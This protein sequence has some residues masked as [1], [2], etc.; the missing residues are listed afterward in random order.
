MRIDKFLANAKFGSRKDVKKI[1]KAKKVFVNGNL[2]LNDD[3]QVKE[4]DII[5]CDGKEVKYVEFV[6]YMLNKPTGYV[7]ATIDNLYPTVV[8]IID[9]YHD[10]FPV[11]RLDVDTTG[12]L[13]ITNDGELAH[14]L[15]SPKKKV[16]KKYFVKFTGE[17][18]ENI[19][20]EFKK[21]IDLKDYIT[22]PGIFE[23]ISD[24]SCYV[25]IHEGKFHQVKLMMKAVGLKVIELKRVSF[26]PIDLD[27]NLE[28]GQYRELTKS[29]LSILKNIPMEV[30]GE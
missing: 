19:P 21:G 8:S 24:D 7:S 15:T 29:E 2:V 25:T 4:N 3:Y 22:K 26:G 18:N 28:E 16:D 6:Y 9:D 11:G 20:E 23:K 14:N 17:Y 10:I 30:E 5:I 27:L 13:F 1:L 12:L